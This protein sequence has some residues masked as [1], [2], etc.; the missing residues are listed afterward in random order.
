MTRRTEKLANKARPSVQPAP[1]AS[2]SSR[3]AQRITIDICTQT[4]PLSQACSAS[5]ALNTRSRRKAPI[6]EPRSRR[7]PLRNLCSGAS[8]A[9]PA[10]ES[11]LDNEVETADEHDDAEIGDDFDA[12]IDDR[13]DSDAA[14]FVENL[15]RQFPLVTTAEFLAELAHR[16][17]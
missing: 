3:R 7:H 13:T 11:T 9:P 2:Q 1:A 12:D 15:R 10:E 6:Q 16:I 4:S 5:V 8:Q 17:G 14:S